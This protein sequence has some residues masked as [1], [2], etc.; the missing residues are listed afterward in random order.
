[1]KRKFI[2]AFTALLFVLAGSLTSSAQV[3]RIQMR[4]DGYLCGN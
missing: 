2:L 3:K 4:I 1:M